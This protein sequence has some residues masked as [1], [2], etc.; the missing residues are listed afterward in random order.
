[1]MKK[2]VFITFPTGGMYNRR[3]LSSTS[4]CQ[5]H[6][7][8]THVTY[9]GS[10]IN[11]CIFN[12]L[13]SAH[14]IDNIFLIATAISYACK[15]FMKSVTGIKVMKLSS[16]HWLWVRVSWCVCLGKPFQR[17]LPCVGKMEAYTTWTLGVVITAPHFPR[18]L[19]MGQINSSGKTIK[20][21]QG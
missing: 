12:T 17:S 2:K 16:C 9:S 21:C 6:K 13:Q 3:W 18:N 10:K 14:K 20:A 8:F 5:F 11:K 4:R 1:M 7:H 15:M 19:W